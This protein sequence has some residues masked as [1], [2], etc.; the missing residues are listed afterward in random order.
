M[1]VR[2]VPISRVAG[3]GTFPNEKDMIDF[4]KNGSVLGAKYGIQGQGSG[5]MPGFGAML[6]DEQIE[7]IVEY[8]RS[9]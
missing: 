5:K 2:S 3:Q 6:T 7:A 1:A 4:I 8:V 9:L